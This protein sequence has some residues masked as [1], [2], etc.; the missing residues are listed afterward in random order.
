MKTTYP[1]F[2]FEGKKRW[3]LIFILLIDSKTNFD[4][5]WHILCI[6]TKETR[7]IWRI[8]FEIMHWF[9]HHIWLESETWRSNLWHFSSGHKNRSHYLILSHFEW[10]CP[11]CNFHTHKE[12][13]HRKKCCC[14][15]IVLGVYLTTFFLSIQFIQES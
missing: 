10:I 13:T 15:L 9:V 2:N 6:L 8:R 3:Y 12:K 4:M 1:K 11:S 14:S 5:S 7:T